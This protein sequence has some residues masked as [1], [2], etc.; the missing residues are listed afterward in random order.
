MK[1]RRVREADYEARMGNIVNA[2]SVI[3]GSLEG[4]ICLG[5]LGV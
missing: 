1:L 5:D 4:N 3:V 2:N